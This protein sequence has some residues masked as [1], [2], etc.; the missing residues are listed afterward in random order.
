MDGLIYK[1]SRLPERKMGGEIIGWSD[2][3]DG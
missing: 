1:G 2:Q 3:S